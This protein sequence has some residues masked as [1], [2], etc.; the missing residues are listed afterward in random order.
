MS[1][2][3]PLYIRIRKLAKERKESLASIERILNFSN[4]LIS[5]WKIREASTDKVSLIA[6][7]FGVSIDY[8]MGNTDDRSVP[9]KKAED[10]FAKSQAGLFRT[11]V[12]EQNLSDE[13]QE[14]LKDDLYD[15][16]KMR[17]EFLKKQKNKKMGSD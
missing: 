11:V 12:R 4:G 2:I 13:D 3:K 8:L 10:V 16:L 7:H 15:Y 6:K 5:T 1:E 9:S 14:T 17:A